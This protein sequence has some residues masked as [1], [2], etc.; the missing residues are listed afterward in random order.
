MSAAE[1][2]CLSGSSQEK[3]KRSKEFTHRGLKATRPSL[4]KNNIMHNIVMANHLAS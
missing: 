2:A 1:L 4:L 3:N